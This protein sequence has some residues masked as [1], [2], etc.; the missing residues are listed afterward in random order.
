MISDKEK[1]QELELRLSNYENIKE[2]LDIKN[3][4]IK[5]F[6]KS[7]P[8]S[9]LIDCLVEMKIIKK[10]YVTREITEI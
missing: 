1:L 7:L 6:I 3:R 5:S 2:K 10:D 8:K 4:C 9:F